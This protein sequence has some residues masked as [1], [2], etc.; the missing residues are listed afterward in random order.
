M[1]Q[2]PKTSIKLLIRLLIRSIRITITLWI[3][4]IMLQKQIML[5]R[6][7]LKYKTLNGRLKMKNKTQIPETIIQ[8]ETQEQIPETITQ[9]Q[10]T[11]ETPET[12]ETSQSSLD[13]SNNDTAKEDYIS[14]CEDTIRLPFDIWSALSNDKRKELT[15]KES[16]LAGKRLY[17]FL[18]YHDMLQYVK[19]DLAF[20]IVL[21]AITSRRLIQKPLSKNDNT[22]TNTTDKTNV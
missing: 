5:Q 20:I 8:E 17:E 10:L 22:N 12:Q 15:A 21:G 3:Y 4:L 9:E 14:L 1:L 11:N 2:K 18:A 16:E 7:K 6:A 19:Q 13:Y